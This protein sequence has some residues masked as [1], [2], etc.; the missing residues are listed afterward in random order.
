MWLRLRHWLALRS[1]VRTDISSHTGRGDV[2]ASQPQLPWWMAP[3]PLGS[4]TAIAVINVVS[5]W[6]IR[7]FANAALADDSSAAQGVAFAFWLSGALS[8][9]VA[10]V[11]ALLLGA[12]A[13]AMLTLGGTLVRF[14]RLLTVL[15]AGQVLLSLDNLF[16]AAVLLVRGIA[17]VTKPA[18][19]WVPQGLDIFFSVGSPVAQAIAGNVTL[20]HVA[21]FAFLVAALPHT[22]GV[23]RRAAIAVGIATWDGMLAVAVARALWLT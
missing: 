18:D 7:P 21:W 15:L 1:H 11:Q 10:L 14:G 8:P 6:L 22:I 20:F 13:W 9:L 16:I 4:L 3:H 17:A 23:S 5:A 12:A 19:L 2:G